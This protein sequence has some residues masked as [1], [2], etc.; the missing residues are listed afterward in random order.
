MSSKKIVAISIV[1]I[2]IGAVFY[3]SDQKLEFNNTGTS[4]GSKDSSVIQSRI[5]PKGMSLYSNSKYNF[6]I[7]YPE[8]LKIN[9]YPDKTSAITI[10][11]QNTEEAKG[12]QIFIVPYSD[13]QISKKRF[14]ADIPSGIRLGEKEIFIRGVPG[15]VFYSKDDFLGDTYE[16]WFIHKGYLYEV[17]TLKSDEVWLNSILNTW[18]FDKQ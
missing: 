10:T 17:T 3:F 4:E 6:S 13:S 14:L 18:Y 7:F 15:V 9:E 1:F 2:F 8:G 16:V 12:F 5:P 11:F